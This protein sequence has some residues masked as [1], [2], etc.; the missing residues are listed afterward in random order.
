MGCRNYEMVKIRILCGRSKAIRRI[1]IL[2]FRRDNFD[3]FKDLLGGILRAKSTV[4]KAKELISTK[5]SLLPSSR[6]VNL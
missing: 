3:L 2:E 6:S 4:G 1:A 5:T